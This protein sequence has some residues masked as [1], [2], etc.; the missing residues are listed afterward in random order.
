VR[1]WQTVWLLGAGLLWSAAVLAL[2]RRFRGPRGRPLWPAA[3]ITGAGLLAIS[4]L[5]L[6]GYGDLADAG[7][8]MLTR[9]AS[10]RSLP[11][12]AEEVGIARELPSG[13]VV[14]LRRELLAWVEVELA[15]GE[16][17]WLRRS[18]L[19]PFYLPAL[20][21]VVADALD[22]PSVPQPPPGGATAT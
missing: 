13:Q 2:A 10:L 8:A 18:S 11:S 12:E 7:A 9:D 6:A 14:R 5:A 20:A 21:P 22:H 1:R 3:A 4:W 17:G 19:A 15:S 16:R